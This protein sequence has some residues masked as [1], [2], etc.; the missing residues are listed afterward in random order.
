MLTI[1]DTCSVCGLSLK[2]HDAADGPTFFALILVGF[3]ITG[4]AGL[5]EYHFAPAMWI[6]AV[7][8]VPLTFLAC[9]GFLRVFKVLFVTLEYRLARLKEAPPH[10]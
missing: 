6:H 3:L 2:H 1:V 5:V 9:I 8:W 7:L 4:G 10:E